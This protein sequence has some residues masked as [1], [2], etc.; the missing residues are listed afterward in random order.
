LSIEC[1]VEAQ[2]EWYDSIRAMI[3][4][5]DTTFETRDDNEKPER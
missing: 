1:F 4:G 5:L 2:D 3:K